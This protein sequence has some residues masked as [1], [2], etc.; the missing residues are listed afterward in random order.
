MTGRGRAK[1]AQALAGMLIAMSACG[2]LAAEAG[3]I[4]EPADYRMEQYRAPVPVTLSGA[5]VVDS[6]GAHALW[7][8]GKTVFI[9]VMPRPPRPKLPAGTVWRE[10]A[11][12]DI[13]GSVWLPNVGYG[14]L[15]PELDVWYRARLKELTGS[16]PTHPILVYCLSDCWMSWNAARRALEY[17]YTDVTWYPEGTDG[18]SAVGLPLEERQPESPTS[19]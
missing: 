11:R 12:L 17:G 1:P 6:A 2:D 13:P 4:A 19:P 16:D 8:R 10:E 18:W 9:D 3:G 5:R 15:P 7:K 14:R